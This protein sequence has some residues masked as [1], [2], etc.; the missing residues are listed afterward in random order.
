MLVR[1][2]VMFGSWWCEPGGTSLPFLQKTVGVALLPRASA[3]PSPHSGVWTP[4]GHIRKE[5]SSGPRIC[6]S[7][8]TLCTSLRAT[9]L[10]RR[11]RTSA[12]LRNP[13]WIHFGV[14]ARLFV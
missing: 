11:P 7:D 4:V 5:V 8:V 9:G 2:A 1:G 6:R 13:L 10:P 14:R 12:V 3:L